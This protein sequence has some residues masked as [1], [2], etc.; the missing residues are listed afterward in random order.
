M[1]FTGFPPKVRYVPVP[2]P[3]FSE[4]LEQIDDIA[5]LKCT[6]RLMWLLHE[7]RSYPRFLTR[8]ELATDRG[9]AKA[10]VSD[11][12]DPQAAIDRTLE[13]VVRRGIFLSGL[14]K[15]TEESE[16]VYALNTE[17]DRKAIARVLNKPPPAGQQLQQGPQD[18]P[19]ERPN[20]FGLYE[21]NIGLLSPMI[22]EELKQTEAA[23]PQS[24]IEDAFREAVSNNKRSLR[25]INAILE[26]WE[27]D[28]KGDG[29][30]LRYPKKNSFEE[31]VGR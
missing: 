24:W 23:Y 29:R 18:G 27:R 15:G 5:E 11:G 21:D 9:L 17:P 13:A 7:K 1:A 16:R 28:G 26:R 25:Y 22:A 6:L 3:L 10:L 30:P 31:R 2:S 14:S 20:I 4:L 8:R 12:S 19:S